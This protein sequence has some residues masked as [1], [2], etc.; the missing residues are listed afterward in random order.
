LPFAVS[1]RRIND[2]NYWMTQRFFSGRLPIP[3][4]SET[5]PATL[6]DNRLAA[7]RGV[8]KQ[9]KSLF[10]GSGRISFH[11]SQYTMFSLISET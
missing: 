9:G 1:D 7:F 5:H 4:N 3:L 6:N 10:R 11:R 2:L 8:E